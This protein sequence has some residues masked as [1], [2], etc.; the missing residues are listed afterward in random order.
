MKK[1]LLLVSL[2]LLASASAV[3]I[4]GFNSSRV[5]EHEYVYYGSGPVGEIISKEHVN[6]SGIPKNLTMNIT[7]SDHPDRITITAVCGSTEKILDNTVTFTNTSFP[8]NETICS[9][10]V[11]RK[12]FGEWDV[13]IDLE[14]FDPD[15]NDILIGEW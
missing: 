2:L 14:A 3:T 1:L 12:L 5:E 7:E 6:I 15:G 8:T 10:R 9:L 4:S 13:L 11:H